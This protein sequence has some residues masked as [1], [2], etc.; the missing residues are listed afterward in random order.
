MNEC[1]VFSLER[2]AGQVV[3]SQAKILRR[4]FDECSTKPRMTLT[5]YSKR[6]PKINMAHQAKEPSLILAI[7]HVANM[8]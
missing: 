8:T 5:H 3:A 1:I 4:C 2:Q 6:N 7:N